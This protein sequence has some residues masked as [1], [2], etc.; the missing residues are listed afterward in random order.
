MYEQKTITHEEFMREQQQEKEAFKALPLEEKLPKTVEKMLYIVRGRTGG[1]E[2]YAKMLL[3]M[4]PNYDYEVCMNY[5]CYKSDND[6]FQAMIEL[7][8]EYSSCKW[9]YAKLVEPYVEELK[10][11]LK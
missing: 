5:W 11:Y 1:S 8:Q 6:D 9:E 4:L 7:M 2:I 10:E 3:S